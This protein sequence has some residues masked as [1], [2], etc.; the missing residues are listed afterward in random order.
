ML[1]GKLVPY[2]FLQLKN[3]TY[4]LH[5]HKSKECVQE[6]ISKA[7]LL[8]EELEENTI[9]W[10][11]TGKTEHGVF[12]SEAQI[13]TLGEKGLIGDGLSIALIIVIGMIGLGGLVA[14]T[15]RLV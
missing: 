5:E 9:V 7:N 11:A 10:G 14:L 1:T 6:A 15:I 4:H 13:L 2:H 3:G 12:E 8:C